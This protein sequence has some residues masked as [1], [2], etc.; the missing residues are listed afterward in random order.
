MAFPRHA[1]MPA[2]GW[3]S[4]SLSHLLIP[5]FRQCGP[6]TSYTSIT[7]E[8]VR[9]RT[10]LQPNKLPWFIA[11]P[12]DSVSSMMPVSCNR[13][14]IYFGTGDTRTVPL[15]AFQGRRILALFYSFGPFYRIREV[16]FTLFK[17]SPTSRTLNKVLF[18]SA[19]IWQS[20]SLESFLLWENGF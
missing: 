5:R 17:G 1:G 2:H 12:R 10:P 14:H 16:Q 3:V 7:W 19:P 4:P 8:L 20:C 11:S 13:L 18:C 15:S 6:Q 9:G